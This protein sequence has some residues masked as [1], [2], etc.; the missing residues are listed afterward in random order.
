MFSRENRD[1]VRRDAATSLFLPC[2][3]LR[4][5]RR[6]THLAASA[7]NKKGGAP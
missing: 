7:N 6:F 2:V 3:E 5:E 4:R 1:L